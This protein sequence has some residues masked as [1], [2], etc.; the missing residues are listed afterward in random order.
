M[1]AEDERFPGRRGRRQPR[2]N[3]ATTSDG[4]AA[5][6]GTAILSARGVTIRLDAGDYGLLLGGGTTA[7]G[8]WGLIGLG[9]GA[10]VRNQ[11]AASVGIFVWMAII[12]NLLVDGA[13]SVSRYMPATLGEAISG[14]RVGAIHTPVLGALLL[15]VY[16]AAAMTA[17]VVVTRRRD[18]A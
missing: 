16:A 17:G 7:A 11:V 5:S 4:V 2:Y 10:V 3:P 9:L 13:P 18:F 1:T 8:L 6:L 14:D 15:A 12:E